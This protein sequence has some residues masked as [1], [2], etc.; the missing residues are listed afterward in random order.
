MSA[1]ER[2]RLKVLHE[3]KQR[4]ITQKQAAGEL[5]LSVR[6]VR[7]LLLRLRERGDSALRHGL[8]GRRS[9]RKTPEAVQRRA[10]ELY[11]QKKQA[12]LWHDYGPTLAAEELSEQHG[13]AISRETLRRWLIEAKLWRRRRARVE[14]AHVWRAR[15][16]R[17]GELV[18]WD[19][20]E[21]DGLEGRGEKLY[22]IAMIDDATSELT[23][24]FV[25][26][27]ST[28]ENLK[29]LRSY[30]V[31]HGRPVSVYTDKASLFQ[32]TPHGIHHRDAPVQ[33]LTQI[34]RALKE[35]NIE[36][37]AAHSPQAKG[38]IERAFQTA[39][40]RLVKGL[41][42]VGAKD[43]ESA[44]AYLEQ[45]FLT[46]WNRRFRRQPQLAGDAHRAL[47]P[48]TNLDSVLSIRASRTVNPDYTVRW[49]GASYRVEREQITRG[50]RGARVQLEQRLD[51]SRWLR[52]R[53]RIL[54]L[55]HCEP[56]PE[57][58]VERQVKTPAT[59][60]RSAKEKAR[61]RQRFLNARRQWRESYNQLR[62]RPI[63]QAMKDASLRAG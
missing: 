33:Q 16:A 31:Q 25:G 38:R 13:I 63:W 48:G 7:T 55:E 41:R 27:D 51:G 24:G 2:D 45:I 15:R 23:A 50:M 44:N 56:R 4:H 19:T 20:S 9:N 22:L 28:E 8:R 32:V 5:G 47:L 34:G 6:W 14:Q 18:Q 1:K 57:L 42:Q 60:M 26:H 39:Q 35:L 43:L 59:T 58:M 10:V 17:Y 61:A 46:L 40:D 12:K 52:W 62:N 49:D 11:R 29:Q 53:H 36:W 54:A 21:H 30:L 3:V 37:I